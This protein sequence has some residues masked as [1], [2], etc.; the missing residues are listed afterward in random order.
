[1]FVIATMGIW[2]NIALLICRLAVSP[3][4]ATHA[5]QHVRRDEGR[6]DPQPVYMRGHAHKHTR[7]MGEARNRLRG[8]G[9][10]RQQLKAKLLML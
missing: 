3:C 6:Q 10:V 4:S 1:M 7:Q 9:A 5:L 8:L 2:V